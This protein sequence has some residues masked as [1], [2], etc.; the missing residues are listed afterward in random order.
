MRSDLMLTALRM[1]CRRAFFQGQLMNPN[2]VVAVTNVLILI[3]L[4]CILF[5][6]YDR[7]QRFSELIRHLRT[8]EQ[9]YFDLLRKLHQALVEV[10]FLKKGK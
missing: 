1:P 7:T 8:L 6:L 3:A 4:T 9:D 10:E 2:T 5:K